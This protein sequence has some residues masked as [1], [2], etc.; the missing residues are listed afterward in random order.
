MP[1]VSLNMTMANAGPVA[2]SWNFS[3]LIGGGYFIT[4]LVV[5]GKPAPG[6]AQVLGMVAYG[7]TGGTYNTTLSGGAHTISL[8]YKTATAFN[9]NPVDFDWQTASLQT[10]AFDQ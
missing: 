6:T 2:V 10:L 9:F 4:Q 3:T 1:N 7:H 8:Q 5:D